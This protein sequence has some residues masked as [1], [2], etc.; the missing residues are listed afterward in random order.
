MTGATKKARE[1]LDQ[2]ITKGEQ[3]LA[4]KRR[5]PIGDY[6]EDERG[7]MQFRMLA[8]TV[9]HKLDPNGHFTGEFQHI[10][11]R[12]GWGNGPPDRL[13]EQ[14]GV[15]EALRDDFDDGQ[16]GDDRQPDRED[17]TGSEP[18]SAPEAADK[19]LVFISCGQA[20]AGEK[21]LGKAIAN[22]AETITGATGYFAENQTSL[23]GLTKNVFGALNRAAALIAVMHKRGRVTN[24]NGDLNRT[25]ASVWVEQE[26]AIASFIQATR[27][28]D[29]KVAAYID[30]E[31]CLRVLAAC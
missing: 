10:D 14:L 2:V 9:L 23:D 13:S 26:I 19:P 3:V 8:K 6:L 15:L 22:M 31:I 5:G 16:A 11:G 30:A 21:Q 20:T 17:D 7:Y 24:E 27:N 25:R 29:L 4:T 12:S 18:K 28:S 1:R